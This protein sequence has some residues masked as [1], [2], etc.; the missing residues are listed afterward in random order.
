[1]AVDRAASEPAS[2]S[3]VIALDR[4]SEDDLELLRLT[5]SPLTLM[6]YSW[7]L[8]RTGAGAQRGFQTFADLAESVASYH[9]RAQADV[10]PEA[11]ADLIIETCA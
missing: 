10:S 11:I 9:L 1:M 7:G 2:P 4:S 8:T 6:G 3:A 5:P